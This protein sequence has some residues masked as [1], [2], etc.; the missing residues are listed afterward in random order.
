MIP[1]VSFIGTFISQ[2]YETTNHGF[3]VH[4]DGLVTCHIIILSWLWNK[5][6]A[7]R[8]IKKALIVTATCIAAIQDDIPYSII[9]NAIAPGNEIFV[10]HTLNG[11]SPFVAHIM[12]RHVLNANMSSLIVS[13]RISQV[14]DGGIILFR[15]F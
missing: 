12:L 14:I 7:G 3:C 10:R 8:Q 15:S 9:F 13:Y 4:R 5:G 6:R 11:Q 2:M 1:I